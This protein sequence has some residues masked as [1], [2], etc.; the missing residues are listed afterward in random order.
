MSHGSAGDYQADERAG[1][2][3]LSWRVLMPPKVLTSLTTS[4]P[5]FSQIESLSVSAMPGSLGYL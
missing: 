5:R 4:R 3:R 2:A 1:L